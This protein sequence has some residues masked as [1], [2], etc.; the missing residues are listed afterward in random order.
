MAMVSRNYAILIFNVPLKLPTS[1]WDNQLLYACTALSSSLP[2][3]AAAT[4]LPAGKGKKGK[5]NGER[6]GWKG[7]REEEREREGGRV[8]WRKE[9]KEREMEEEGK[10]GTGSKEEGG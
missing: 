5:G 9:R 2:Q 3:L 1:P 7:C 8:E 6:T 4:Y 10:K